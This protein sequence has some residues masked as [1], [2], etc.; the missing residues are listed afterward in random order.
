MALFFEFRNQWYFAYC[1]ISHTGNRY[2]RDTFISYVHYKES[3]E[4]AL[5]RVDGTGAHDLCFV[6]GGKGAD[7]LKF[8]SFSLQ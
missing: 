7:L 2:F 3:G 5:I 4:M 8:D 6:F 1:D